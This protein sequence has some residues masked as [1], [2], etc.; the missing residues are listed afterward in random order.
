MIVLM[1]TLA[2]EGIA[3]VMPSITVVW[4]VAI[5]VAPITIIPTMVVAIVIM[6]RWLFGA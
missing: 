5:V 1:R 6:A 2:S 4:E 3:A